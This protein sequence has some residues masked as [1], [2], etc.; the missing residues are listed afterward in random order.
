MEYKIREYMDSLFESA[1]RTQ[2][3]Y[4]LKIELTQNLI[5]K[6]YAFVGEGKTQEDAFNLT[7][8][9]IGDVR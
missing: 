3:A 2:R 1:P 6:Y 8:G 5:E 7:V 4:E 9:S